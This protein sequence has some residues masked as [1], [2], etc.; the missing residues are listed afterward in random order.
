M[1]GYHNNTYLLGFSAVD[2]KIN[3]LPDISPAKMDLFGI[4]RELHFGVCNHGKPCASSF[5]AKEGEHFYREEKE[6]GRAIIKRPWLF[7]G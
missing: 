5:M 3:R 6:V 4:S 7:I 1:D 2:L